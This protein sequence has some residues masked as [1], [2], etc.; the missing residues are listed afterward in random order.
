MPNSGIRVVEHL[1]HH[2]K[3]NGVCLATATRSEG[4]NGKKSTKM[5]NCN[6]RVVELSP[7]YFKIKG[8]CPTAGARSEGDV[9]KN[10]K[11]KCPTGVAE[12]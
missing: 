3:V 10:I 1:P 5:P 9:C 8:S 12:W 2:P 7:H 4:D 11:L 6:S